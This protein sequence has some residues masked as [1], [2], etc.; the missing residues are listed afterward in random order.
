[1]EQAS[2]LVSRSKG[3]S[4]PY[5]DE[6][7]VI[8]D[9]RGKWTLTLEPINNSDSYSS[10]VRW[11]F[12][13]KNKPIARKMHKLDDDLVWLV[14]RRHALTKVLRKVCRSEDVLNVT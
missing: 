2:E 13:A 11:D 5:S 6:D 12:N 4:T 7:D 1:M 8:K 9:F 14:L 3:S 10:T